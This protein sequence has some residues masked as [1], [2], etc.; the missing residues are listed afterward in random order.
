MNEAVIIIL[1]GLIAAAVIYAQW[2]DREREMQFQMIAMAVNSLVD[3][4][5]KLENKI[6]EMEERGQ[7]NNRNHRNMK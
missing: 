7:W 4:V 5:E 1:I 2:L 3:S 6:A